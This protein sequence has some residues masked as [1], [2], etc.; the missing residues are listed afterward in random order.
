MEDC[1]EMNTP[2]NQKEKLSKD[3]GAEKCSIRFMH[4]DSE[5]HLKAAKRVVW[6]IKGTVDYG[7]KFQKIPNMKLFGY[8]D[9]DW[10]GSLDDMKSTSSNRDSKSS[11]VAEEK[12]G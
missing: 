4:Y 8:S 9:S 5:V 2:M 1:K 12:F 6:Y 3:D 7:V 11:I 10:G